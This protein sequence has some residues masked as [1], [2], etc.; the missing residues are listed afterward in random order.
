MRSRT[1]STIICAPSVPIARVVRPVTL[2]VW[3]AVYFRHDAA[4]LIALAD[5]AAAIGI[6]RFV[7]DDGWFGDR[8]T[9]RAG[10]GDWVVSADVWP[11]GLHPLVDHVRAKGM[12]FGLWFEPEMV[13]LDS[14][15]AR[16]HP[17]WIMAAR[18]ELPS[19]PRAQHV[20]NLAAP[21]SVRAR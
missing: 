9:D 1:G 3:E 15:L 7:L 19:S 4:E 2:N 20:L 11:D 5:Q 17:E 14:E 12:Q 6:E 21:G 8:R 16:R 10:L 18:D 13:N